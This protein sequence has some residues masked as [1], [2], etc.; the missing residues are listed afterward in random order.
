M[1]ALYLNER[2][3]QIESIRYDDKKNKKSGLIERWHQQLPYKTKPEWFDIKL[4]EEGIDKASFLT[5]AQNPDF[6]A[7]NKTSKTAFNPAKTVWCKRFI[8]E[9][10]DLNYDFYNPNYPEYGF[11][12]LTLP[13]VYSSSKELESRI[14]G[15]VA[16]NPH[17]FEGT[18]QIVRFL[19]LSLIDKFRKL[20]HKTLVLEFNVFKA[21]NKLNGATPEE[22]FADFT[23]Q[24]KTKK[25]RD[26]IN[27]DYPVLVR[28][29]VEEA[30]NWVHHSFQFVNRLA[31][32][33][34]TI[35]HKLAEGDTTKFGKFKSVAFGAGDTH[36]GGNS[37][38][39]V[40]FETGQKIVYKPRSLQIDAHFQNLLAWI[41]EKSSIDFKQIQVIQRDNYGWVEFVE[42]KNCQNTEGV[43]KYYER[44]G[45]YIALLYTLEAT[46]FHYENIIANGEY[47]MLIDLESFFHPYF[48]IEGTETNQAN[49]ASVLR[50]GL[51]PIR[52][53]LKEGETG[54]EVSGITDVEGQQGLMQV[55]V[56]E[57]LGSD[58]VRITKQAG[59]LS[60]GKNIPMLNGQ[61]VK[62]TEEDVYS[63]KR[64]FEAVYSCFMTEKAALKDVLKQFLEDEVRVLF[65]DTFVYVHLL[66]ESLHPKVLRNGLECERHFDWLWAV[67]PDYVLIK[68]IIKYEKQSLLRGDVPL[69]STNVN[70]RHLWYDDGQYIEN[71]FTE[72]GFELVERKIDSLN[73]TDLKKQVWLI[74]AS[75]FAS[76]HFKGQSDEKEETKL[77]NSRFSRENIESQQLKDKLLL[78]AQRV[79]DYIINHAFIGDKEAHWMALKREDSNNYRLAPMNQDLFNGASGEILF[80]AYLHNATRE[81]KYK[82]L[83]EKA[84]TG[85]LAK[86]QQ[87]KESIRLLGLHTG[88][89]SVI[90]LLT[91]LSHLW[92]RTDLQDYVERLYKDIDF[93]EL[94]KV[95]KSYSLV[96]GSAGFMLA[97]L[98]FHELT[99]SNSALNWAKQAANYLLYEAKTYE[100]GI[101]WKISGEISLSGM[102]HGASGFALAF[103]QLFE[104]TRDKTYLKAIENILSYE[105]A[106]FISEQ[107]NWQDCRNSVRYRFPNRAICATGWAHG[108]P[109][110]GITRLDL[111]TNEALNKEKIEADLTSALNTGLKRS[112]TQNQCYTMGSFGNLEFLHNYGLRLGDQAVLDKVMEI[113]QFYLNYNGEKG[114]NC[115][116]P[117]NLL[118][119]GLITGVTGIGY[120]Y[121]RMATPEKTP[122]VLAAQGV[123]I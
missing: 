112:I 74:E 107:Q 111:R 60:G 69:F 114:W 83:A 4:Q 105:N 11:L 87:G 98:K 61:K 38:A 85:L 101:G 92:R 86:I 18:Q 110:I 67:V 103:N 15:I 36:R 12:N 102:A 17:A 3:E 106:L 14:Q 20:L 70:S 116:L 93:N 115:G 33:Y 46:D 95:D 30:D 41:S 76:T 62:M 96:K 40:T 25:V 16:A 31:K 118:T 94:I 75:L 99:G 80:L 7:L 120:Q 43:K 13:L 84:L 65:R 91:H 19:Q 9:S 28:R 58:N 72:T 23:R 37:V 82:T 88:W 35:I 53:S 34:D 73:E 109:G 121:L 119:Q 71:F 78:E 29:L 51:L 108:A 100:N 122:S 47:P 59:H 42:H 8:S 54:M 5:L 32:D 2:I 57:G 26:Y 44:I 39:I 123:I 63:M 79:G 22:R 81:E 24:L 10:I 48:P 52:L 66:N 97:N 64:G 89:G 55:S 6:H 27:R 104:L 56:T 21:Q 68:K 77:T 50:T 90:Y 117:N 49:E 1:N 113:A 45:G